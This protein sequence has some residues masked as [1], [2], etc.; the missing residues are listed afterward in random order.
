MVTEPDP[1]YTMAGVVGSVVPLTILA[2]AVFFYV[3]HRRRR[4]AQQQRIQ[5]TDGLDLYEQ[6]APLM[7]GHPTTPVPLTLY[8][9]LLLSAAK[10]RNP[11]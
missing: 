2:A 6:R 4:Q 8:V 7:H 5:S 10:L 9:S 3:R 11:S 1:E